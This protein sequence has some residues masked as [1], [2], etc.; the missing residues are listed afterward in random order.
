[1]LQTIITQL[2]PDYLTVENEPTLM[3][4]ST[5]LNFSSDSMSSY[6]SYFVKNLTK[7]STKICAGA[8]HGKV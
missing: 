2:K 7:N 4:Q 8:V 6:V 3:A 5:N 1:M